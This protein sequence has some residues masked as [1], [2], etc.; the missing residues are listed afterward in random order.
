[1]AGK[2]ADVLAK[3]DEED[4][5]YLAGFP[6]STVGSME[7]NLNIL[8]Y[9]EPGVGKTVLAGSASV[10]PEMSPVLLLDVEGGTMS[11]AQEYGDV[12]VIRIHKWADLQ[13]VY[14]KLYSGDHKYRTVI[15]DSLS[16]GQKLSMTDIMAKA[17]REDPDLDRD[18]P[19]M[20]AWGQ[21]LEQ[22]RRFTRGL[23][24]LPMNVIFTAL[25]DSNKNN[26][27]KDAYRPS[28]QGKTK[29]EV[30]GFMDIVAYYYIVQKGDNQIRVL[31]SQQTPEVIAKDRTNK[32]PKIMENP[33]MSAIYSHIMGTVPTTE[34]K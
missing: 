16:E 26:K 1:M 19:T 33:T 20:R 29:A 30:P 9:G 8:I 25:V 5:Q 24:D 12:D 3:D 15:M 21:N 7:T 13:K 28:F 6:I 4:K 11:L 18:V 27:G 14:N 10:V 32:L 23:R 2:L 34:E 31:L 17:V 22:M